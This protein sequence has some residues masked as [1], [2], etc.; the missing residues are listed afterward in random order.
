MKPHHFFKAVP[1]LVTKLCLII[2]CETFHIFVHLPAHGMAFGCRALK[3][4]VLF[5]NSR[6][7]PETIHHRSSELARLQISRPSWISPEV[8]ELL[9]LFVQRS[10]QFV[11]Y[12]AR[13]NVAVR[14][15]GRGT[16]ESQGT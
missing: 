5:S 2:V 1:S 3:Y 9:V 10:E 6:S 8:M 4:V 7:M 16:A 15:A 11:D 12:N 14:R 13:Y